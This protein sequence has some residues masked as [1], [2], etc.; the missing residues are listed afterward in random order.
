MRLGEMG[1][2]GLPTMSAMTSD[3]TYRDE[4]ACDVPIACDLPISWRPVVVSST[5]MLVK[6][7]LP[8]VRSSSRLSVYSV[9]VTDVADVSG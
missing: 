1:T 3:V 8:L 7:L 5:C 6:S 2:T 9:L 4:F